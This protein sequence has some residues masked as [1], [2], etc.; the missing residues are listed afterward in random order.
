MLPGVETGFGAQ[1]QPQQQ[2]QL[3]PSSS[4]ET[5]DILS[6]AGG[7]SSRTISSIGLKILKSWRVLW[8]DQK[9]TTVSSG[10]QPGVVQVSSVTRMAASSGRAK[11]S[12][13]S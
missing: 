6:Q 9:A 1:K 10:G 12:A 8:S 5:R 3:M 7:R 13:P 11:R 2:L 4:S